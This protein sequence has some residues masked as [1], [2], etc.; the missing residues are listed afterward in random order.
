MKILLC[1]IFSFLFSVIMLELKKLFGYCFSWHLQINFIMLMCHQ[2]YSYLLHIGEKEEI[3]WEGG[4]WEGRKWR[5][6]ESKYEKQEIKF[7]PHL[8]IKTWHRNFNLGWVFFCF[9]LLIFYYFILLFP[10]LLISFYC[11]DNGWLYSY[12][13]LKSAYFLP[14]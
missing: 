7:F 10:Y 2:W 13:L 9:N 3:K 8:Q 6:K 14:I 4:C 11:K 1:V 5:K 12:Q